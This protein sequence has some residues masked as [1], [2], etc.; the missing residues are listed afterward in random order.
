VIFANSYLPG[1][2]G[3]PPDIVG[4]P[5]GLVIDVLALLW[6]ALGAYLIWTTRSLTVASIALLAATGPAVVVLIFAPAAMRIM[7]NL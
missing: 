4:L 7:V 3:K 1:I 6:A 2:L 5:L